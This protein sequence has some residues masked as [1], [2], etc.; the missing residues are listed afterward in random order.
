MQVLAN[1]DGWEKVVEVSD[2]AAHS[3]SIEVGFF[4]QPDYVPNANPPNVDSLGGKKYRLYYRG[5][6]I[7]GYFLFE[8]CS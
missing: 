4:L 2:H 5:R 3:G 1:I 6:K 8:W 7:R